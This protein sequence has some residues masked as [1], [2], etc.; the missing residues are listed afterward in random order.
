MF[1]ITHQVKKARLL[2]WMMRNM[3]EEVGERENSVTPTEAMLAQSCSQS[4]PKYMSQPNH[5]LPTSLTVDSGM[6]PA[7][8]RKKLSTNS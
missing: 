6:S 5:C 1:L 2:G 4:T 7:K 8:M 3:E